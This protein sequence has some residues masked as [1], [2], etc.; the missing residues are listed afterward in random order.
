MASVQEKAVNDGLHSIN[1]MLNNNY[2]YVPASITVAIAW[3]NEKKNYDDLKDALNNAKNGYAAIGKKETNA[4]GEEYLRKAVTTWENALKESDPKSRKARV[5]QEV[6]ETVLIDLSQAY[7]WLNDFTKAQEYLTKLDNFNI[8]LRKKNI[9]NDIKNF[10]S[11]QG[12][13]VT[14]NKGN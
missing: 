3:V 7:I 6:T 5:N 9:R 13:R 1:E 14:A 2:G 12:P 10:L 11:D 8:H 4:Q